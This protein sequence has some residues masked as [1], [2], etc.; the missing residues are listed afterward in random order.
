MP[1]VSMSVLDGVGIG[2]LPNH[3]QYGGP[4]TLL[5]LAPPSDP[6][7]QFKK[8]KTAVKRLLS[9]RQRGGGIR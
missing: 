7:D 5:G 6:K 3:A 9:I 2:S 1:P 8:Q 4:V